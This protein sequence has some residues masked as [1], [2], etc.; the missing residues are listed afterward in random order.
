V[1][2]PF[3]SLRQ[4]SLAITFHVINIGSFEKSLPTP[5]TAK[6]PLKL[7]KLSTAYDHSG[8]G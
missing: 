3:I 2:L 1:E 4:Q 5:T 6:T 8:G 7:Q